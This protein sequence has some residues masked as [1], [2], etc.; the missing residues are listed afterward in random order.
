MEKIL[1]LGA[2]SKSD[3]GFDGIYSKSYMKQMGIAVTEPTVIESCHGCP[4]L[5]IKYG[6]QM[7]SLV[8]KGK[9]VV[10]VLQGG[11]YF[12]L[13]SIQATKTTYPIISVPMD[14]VAYQGFM[15]PSGAAVIGTVGVERKSDSPSRTDELTTFQRDRAIK[16]AEHILNLNNDTVAVRGDGKTDRL[17]KE[18]NKFDIEISDESDLIL[19]LGSKPLFSE[20]SSL[21]QIWSD[22]NNDCNSLGHITRAEENLAYTPNTLQV[23][24][25]KNL[26]IYAA[27]ILSLQRPKIRDKLK[28]LVVKKRQSYEERDLL[29]ELGL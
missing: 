4:D 19:T 26:A 16:M 8:E 20:E 9:K 24:G 13:P 3:P 1:F 25:D 12:A 14:K 18:L 29:K 22:T 15:V 7:Q 28:E 5:M 11:L 27:K 23:R 17:K 6:E 21:I 10:G 2:G